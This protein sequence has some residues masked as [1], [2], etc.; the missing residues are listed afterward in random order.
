M[1]KYREFTPVCSDY[2]RLLMIVMALKKNLWFSIFIFLSQQEFITNK[3]AMAN[4][5]IG[6]SYS[7]SA[8]HWEW[9]DR[10]EHNMN[11]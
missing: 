1:K 2:F 4:Y 3:T 7:E 6:L 11:L 10:R 9:I 8:K 5:F